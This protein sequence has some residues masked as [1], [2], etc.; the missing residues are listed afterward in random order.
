[1][2]K[3]NVCVVVFKKIPEVHKMFL[4]NGEHGSN[5]TLIFG[6]ARKHREFRMAHAGGELNGHKFLVMIVGTIVVDDSGSQV[7]IQ[8]VEEP[9]DIVSPDLFAGMFD[10]TFEE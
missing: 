6:K 7:G 8:C 2:Y 5:A 3:D 9:Y 4:M 10:Q 1:M